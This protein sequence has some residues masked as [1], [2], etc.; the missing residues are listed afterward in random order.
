MGKTLSPREV[1]RVIRSGFETLRLPG[2]GG[3]GSGSGN[4][5]AESWRTWEKW[6]EGEEKGFLKR[7]ARAAVEDARRVVRGR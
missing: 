5:R 7:A 4:G 2:G 6:R 3:A 1:G